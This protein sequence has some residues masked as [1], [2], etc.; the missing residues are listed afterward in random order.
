MELKKAE[1]FLKKINKLFESLKEEEELSRLELDLMRE[2]VRKF[3]RKIDLIQKELPEGLEKPKKEEPA[4]EEELSDDQDILEVEIEEYQ[5]NVGRIEPKK[6]KK[7]DENIAEKIAKTS[8]AS[9][10]EEGMAELEMPSKELEVSEAPKVVSKEEP[11]NKTKEEKVEV[12]KVLDIPGFELEVEDTVIEVKKQPKKPSIQTV[13]QSEGQYSELFDVEEINDLSQKLSA[14]P[15]SDIRSSMG[16]NER[17]LTINELF[18]GNAMAFD[19]TIKNLNN[20]TS[21]EAAKKYLS[22]QVIP[23]YEWD[24]PQKIKKAKVLL[25]LIKRRYN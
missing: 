9:V 18:G 10:E 22:E 25:K 13:D 12:E 15:I 8:I 11:E 16:L 21:F 19:K 6:K 3:Y 5:Y 17:V 1:K 23:E 20:L 7:E 2:Y 24:Q 4:M 14:A